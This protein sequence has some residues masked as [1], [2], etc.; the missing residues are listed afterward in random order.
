[1]KEAFRLF[2]FLSLSLPLKLSNLLHSLSAPSLQQSTIFIPPP[3]Q[4]LPLIFPSFVISALYP[5]W[6]ITHSPHLFLSPLSPPPAHRFTSSSLFSSQSP[7]L[8]FLFPLPPPFSLASPCEWQL[9][10]LFLC[11]PAKEM[12]FLSL[13]LFTC[14][15]HLPVCLY[16]LTRQG[17]LSQALTEAIIC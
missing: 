17:F 14:L 6:P 8:I 15:S 3:P 2:I 16:H 1:M 9:K 12:V 7:S 13:C 5:P 10:Q 4:P 11:F